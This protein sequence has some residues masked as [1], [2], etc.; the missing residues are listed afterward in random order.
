MDIVLQ[1]ILILLGDK[2]GS[3]KELAD[4]LDIAGN[5]ITNWKNGHS[6]SYM[7]YLPQ[8]AEY[9]G[10]SLDWLSGLTDE[11]EPKEKPATI[12]DDELNEIISIFNGL[13]PDNRPKLLEL[14]R[15]YLDAQSKNSERQ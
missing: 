3:V 5:S 8:I 1:R 6:K 15:L 11:K 4:Y 14:A 10:V 2:H 13:S 9:Y 7:K 12:S